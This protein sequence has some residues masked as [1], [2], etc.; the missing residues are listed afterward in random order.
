MDELFIPSRDKFAKEF[1]NILVFLSQTSYFLRK[2]SSIFS[3]KNIEIKLSVTQLTILSILWA[4]NSNSDISFE[5]RKLCKI[6]K[7]NF[8]KTIEPLVKEKLILFDLQTKKVRLKKICITEK[9]INFMEELENVIVKKIRERN[10]L[11]I[12]IAFLSQLKH[13]I[14]Y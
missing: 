9:G 8:I 11:S 7:S 14:K 4:K 10:E 2:L 6:K 12:L 1:S 5:I 13:L 3:F